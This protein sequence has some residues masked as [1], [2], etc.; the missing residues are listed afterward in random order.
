MSAIRSSWQAMAPRSRV[1]A[2]AGLIVPVVLVTALVGGRG[3]RRP[4]RRAHHRRWPTVHSPTATPTFPPLP[5][6]P[7]PAPSATPEPSDEP[8]AGRRRSAPR[9]RWPADAAPDGHR[10]S[11]RPSGQPHRR[12]DGRVDR[13]D[14]R[15]ERGLQRPSRYLRLPASEVREVRTEG[16]RALSAPRGHDGERRQGHEAGRSRGHSTSRSTTTS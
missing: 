3:P 6:T 11:A 2:V 4:C 15:Q 1:V 10:L 8:S 16:Q 14:D 7:S 12:H 9:L 5:P 13:P